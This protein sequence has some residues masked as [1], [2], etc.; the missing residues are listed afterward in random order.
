MNWNQPV[1]EQCWITEHAI[2]ALD[3]RGVV[4]VKLPTVVRGNDVEVEQ[5]CRCGSPTIMGVYVR[6]DPRTVP[7]PKEDTPED[8]SQHVRHGHSLRSWG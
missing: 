4:G 5:C 3:T 2:Y 8:E 1:C 6:I 7:Y